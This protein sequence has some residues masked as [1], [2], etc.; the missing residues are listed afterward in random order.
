MKGSRCGLAEVSRAVKMKQW[1]WKENINT[2][3]A[4]GVFDSCEP[5]KFREDMLRK[6]PSFRYIFPVKAA[7]QTGKERA[8]AHVNTGMTG[9]ER[10]EMDCKRKMM[11]CMF[12]FYLRL[13]TTKLKLFTEDLAKSEKKKKNPFV[14]FS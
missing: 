12:L 11:K 5:V 3:A 1:L 4:F 14:P 6:F 7:V 8:R 9:V 10:A 2:C 13:L